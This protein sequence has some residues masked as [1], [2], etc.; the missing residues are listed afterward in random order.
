MRVTLW[1]NQLFAVARQVFTG[2]GIGN[3]SIAWKLAR[4]AARSFEVNK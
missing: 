1:P 4:A 3:S 2:R